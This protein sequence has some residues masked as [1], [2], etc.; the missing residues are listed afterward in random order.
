M[1]NTQQCFPPQ[2]IPVSFLDSAKERRKRP[3]TRTKLKEW[4][5]ES[6]Q[7]VQLMLTLMRSNAVGV[8]F[9]DP[10]LVAM[11]KA[12]ASTGASALLKASH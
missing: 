9:P 7:D 4:T 12:P 3:L 2:G 11:Q 10:K 8:S 6:K 1:E 5:P